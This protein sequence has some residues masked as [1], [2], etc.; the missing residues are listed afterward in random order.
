[1]DCR[2]HISAFWVVWKYDTLLG[3][4]RRYFILPVAKGRLMKSSF[5]TGM[6]IGWFEQ[7]Q[8]QS[9]YL[10]VAEVI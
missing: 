3:G 8:Y 6:V 2:Y 7:H 5:H 1:M 4:G 10:L 9:L